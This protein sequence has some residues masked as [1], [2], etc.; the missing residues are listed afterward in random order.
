VTDSKEQKKLEVPTR[1]PKKKT[2]GIFDNLR[3]LPQPHPVEE[4]LGLAQGDTT[5]STPSTPSSPS[6][7]STPSIPSGQQNRPS[8]SV[9]P[10]RDYARV[11]NSIVRNAIPSGIFGEQGGKSKELYDYLYSLTRG[12]VVPKRKVR[13][14]K[15]KLMKGA[16]IGSEVTLRKNLIRL[17]EVRLVKEIQFPG[18]HG[19]NEYEVLLPE[20]V[21][22]QR[23]ITPS[24]PSTPSTG[25]NPRQI[26]EG[27]EALEDRASRPGLSISTERSSGE[28][29]TISLIPQ[30]TIDDDDAAL[31]G[32]VAALKVVATEITGKE[33]S[34]SEQDRWR[35]LGEVLATEC[36]IAAARTTVS[37]APSFLAE[38]LRR[39]LWK[40]DKGQLQAEAAQQSAATSNSLSL[41]QIKECPDCGGTNFYYPK[42]YDGGVAKCRHEKLEAASTPEQK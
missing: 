14:P 41:E 19:G 27:V 26:R 40:K 24:T 37:S 31:A 11:A 21:G 9:A 13:I 42:G 10:E 17:R 15:G 8:S 2:P 36:K 16:G 25:S 29:K 33:P 38:H 34:L 6:T 22:L 12:A 18:T 28:D 23:G 5:G 39:R 7:G 32:L 4:I 3:P 30:Q 35:E 1:T 20:E